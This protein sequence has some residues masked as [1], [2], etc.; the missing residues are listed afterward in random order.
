MKRTLLLCLGLLLSLNVKAQ[1]D[2]IFTF[3][4]TIPCTVK[5]IDLEL[6]K[7]WHPGEELVNSISKNTVERIKYKS[8]REQTITES[9]KFEP[10]Q[11]VNEF[12]K[13]LITEVEGDVRGL[14]EFGEIIV[15]SHASSMSKVKAKSFKELKMLAA[16]RGGNV[17]ILK[18]KKKKI[19]HHN[20]NNFGHSSSS[21]ISLSLIGELY[22]SIKPSFKAFQK[23]I[24]DTKTVI[25]TKESRLWDSGKKIKQR[26]INYELDVHNIFHENG[27]IYLEG[28]LEL[29]YKATKFKV[30][31]ISEDHFNVFYYFRGN[32][33]NMEVKYN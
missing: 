33:F 26:K 5:E 8:G 13:V 9:I 1:M 19:I 24:G 29:D 15:S 30:V 32:S 14:F 7:Y 16:L 20:S 27:S 12:D 6:I 3:T 31:S 2:T 18:E 4:E 23:L 25:C 21:S 28:K 11:D 10:I 22:T 17:V